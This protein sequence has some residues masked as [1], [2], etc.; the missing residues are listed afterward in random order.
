MKYRVI[1]VTTFSVL[2]I[3]MSVHTVSAS[4]EDNCKAYCDEEPYCSYC[5]WGNRCNV[6]DE[7][8][9]T[10][11]ASSGSNYTACARSNTADTL[12]QQE[13]ES[14]CDDNNCMCST[15]NFCG[16][17]YEPLSPRQDFE[18]PNGVGAK[19]TACQKDEPGRECDDDCS[20]DPYC[21]YCEKGLLC[22]PGYERINYYP[23]S[24]LNWSS[25]ANSSTADTLN[26]Q[27][28]ESYCDDNNCICS[29]L[30][31]CGP[32]YE[33]LSPRQDFEG[34]KGVGAKYTAGSTIG[35]YRLME[36]VGEGGMGVVFVAE[37][38]RPVRRKVALKIIKPGMDTKDVIAR[39]E[40]ERQALALMDHPNIA[41]VLDAGST[42]SGR[43][44]F[45]MELVRGIPIT[46]YCDRRGPLVEFEDAPQSRWKNWWGW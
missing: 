22:N 23:E 26:Q 4:N 11:S 40:A 42:E 5:D 1:F 31:F 30:N 7:K 46:E 39:F 24:G 3:L 6:G 33:P 45:V 37:Q 10:Y 17:G 28:C 38:D 32:G 21:S 44:Y 12:N 29:T 34:P 14:Y 36:Q 27:N 41:K 8:I 19:Y 20:A 2:A 18:G 16:P 15:L 25:C 43:P 9:K 13:C 35:R